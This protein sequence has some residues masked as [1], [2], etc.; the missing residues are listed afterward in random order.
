MAEPGILSLF[1]DPNFLKA[2][3]PELVS[4]VKGI[5][6]ILTTIGILVIIYFVFLIVTAIMNFI[7]NIRIGKIYKKVNEMDEKL[8]FLVNREKDKELSEE[9]LKH[10]KDKKK[11]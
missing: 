4:G 8:N 7:R 5:L 11:L 2:L 1:T 3:P 9:K 6:V 10:K